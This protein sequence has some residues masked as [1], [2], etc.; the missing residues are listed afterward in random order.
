MEIV[1]CIISIARSMVSPSFQSFMCRSVQ[2]TMTSVK[3]LM[4][5]LW[6]IGCMSFLCLP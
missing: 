1:R 6:N 4:E 3:P 5:A 2:S